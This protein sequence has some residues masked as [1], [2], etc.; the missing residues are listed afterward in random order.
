MTVVRGFIFTIFF[1]VFSLG[2]A[3]GADVPAE[4][5]ANSLSPGEMLIYDTIG[6][7]SKLSVIESTLDPEQHALSGP[8]LKANIEE[9]QVGGNSILSTVCDYN[10][11]GYWN[12]YQTQVGNISISPYLYGYYSYYYTVARSNIPFIQKPANSHE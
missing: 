5:Q 8:Q 9:D 1:T 10:G 6:E 11:F 7:Y 4:M 2:L 12:G 3:V